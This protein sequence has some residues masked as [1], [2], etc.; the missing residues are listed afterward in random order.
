VAVPGASFDIHVHEQAMTDKL[1]RWSMMAA[2][3][4]ELI[5]LATLVVLEW[6]K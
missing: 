1:Y 2:M 4:L 5:L 6:R 3:A